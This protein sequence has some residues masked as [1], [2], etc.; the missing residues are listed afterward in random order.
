[1]QNDMLR[2]DHIS[3]N[4]ANST[5]PGYRRV[6]SSNVDFADVLHRTAVY[7]TARNIPVILP[8]VTMVV[9]TTAGPIKSSGQPLDLALS[10]DGYFEV[11]TP[12]GPAYTRAGNFHIDEG[13]R[14]VNQDG[15]AV[16]GKGGE[17]FL[18]GKAVPV[19]S[20]D[21]EVSDGDIAAGQLRIIAFSDKHGLQMG[22]N[23]LLVPS[24]A[25]ADQ[26]E[27]SAT[28]KS[29]YLES[30]NVTPLNEMVRM[31]ETSRHFESQQK[32]FQGYDE[33]MSAAIQKLGQF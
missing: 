12:H 2:M 29:G 17:I 5:T 6:L 25:E 16:S 9:D 15:F 13:G 24:T 20:A 10:G 3:L 22:S 8:V 23:G 33:Q 1:M 18:S 19:I 32:L 26:I 31:L 28:V 11:I 27:S 4:V 14:L 30:S 21:G 7:D